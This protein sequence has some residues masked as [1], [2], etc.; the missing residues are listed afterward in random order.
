MVEIE[1]EKD[2]MMKVSQSFLLFNLTIY[3][4]SVLRPR[5]RDKAGAKLGSCLSVKMVMRSHCRFT[6]HGIA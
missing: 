5:G 2:K 4:I 3:M 1:I 6:Q